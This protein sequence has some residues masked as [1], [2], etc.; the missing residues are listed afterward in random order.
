MPLTNEQ[1]KFFADYIEQ[2]VGIV[3]QPN[4]YF[5]LEKRLNEVAKALQLESVELLYQQA[6]QGISGNLKNLLLDVATNNE[7]SFFRDPKLFAAVEQKMIPDIL[8]EIK[9]LPVLR[10]WS[11]ACSHGQE[12][13]TLGMITQELRTLKPDLPRVD[14]YATDFSDKAL[15]KARSGVYNQLEIQRGLPAPL[16]M[17]YFEQTPEK[18]WRVMPELRSLVRFSKLNLIE[19]FPAFGSFEV[20]FCRNV[21]I[22]Q[23]QESKK[24]VIEK[25]YNRLV[26]NGYLVLGAQES[27]VG[28]SDKFGQIY[29]AG[30]IYFKKTQ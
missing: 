20:I 29:H 26:P 13:Y 14:I 9:P 28:L 3:Y 2:N 6:R 23:T 16:M 11:A 1:I 12:P 4:N 8:A 21:L 15:E 24:D 17:K 30:A 27:M 25:L 7:S 18:E 5:Q 10:I 19:P 22:Y